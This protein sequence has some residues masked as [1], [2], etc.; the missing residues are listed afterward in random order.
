[1]NYI[2]PAKNLDNDTIQVMNVVLKERSKE[3]QEK[4]VQESQESKTK[5]SIIGILKANTISAK[6]MFFFTNI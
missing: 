1:M 4:N 2:A 6:K 5:E 3:N